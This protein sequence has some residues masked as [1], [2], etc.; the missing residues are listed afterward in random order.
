MNRDE[1]D[2]EESEESDSGDTIEEDNIEAEVDD[3]TQV[4]H[5][6]PILRGNL[7]T[8]GGM[9]GSPVLQQ[10]FLYSDKM[11]TLSR[12]ISEENNPR[13]RSSVDGT[14]SPN[15]IS[16][17]NS[18]QSVKS[19][20]SRLSNLS[21]KIS[22]VDIP[23]NVELT[24]G[25]SQSETCITSRIGNKESK[26]KSIQIEVENNELS[27][28]PQSKVKI[29]DRLMQK[30][31]SS[32]EDISLS[33]TDKEQTDVK[34][35]AD[36]IREKYKNLIK[37][38]NREFESGGATTSFSR[39]SVASKSQCGSRSHVEETKNAATVVTVKQCDTD[40]KLSNEV[41]GFKSSVR[42]KI[43]IDCNETTI[44][45]TKNLE[46]PIER[47]ENERDTDLIVIK[48]ILLKSADGEKSWSGDAE[49]TETQKKSP[50]KETTS[51]IADEPT[52][53]SISPKNL[54][55]PVKKME[56]RS[57][58]GSESEEDRQ[59]NLNNDHLN[60]DSVK[61]IAEATV[62]KKNLVADLEKTFISSSNSCTSSLKNESK[63][64]F[65]THK[66]ISSIK[67]DEC[68]E[69]SDI[70]TT[71][72]KMDLFEITSPSTDQNIV[73]NALTDP[74]KHPS[75][76]LLVEAHCQLDSEKI[77][78]PK[79]TSV[80]QYTVK[81]VE[82]RTKPDL[83][84]NTTDVKNFSSTSNSMKSIAVK[85]QTE[86]ETPNIDLDVSA[87]K[88]PTK[89]EELS[90]TRS[91]ES[92]S[93]VRCYNAANI[94]KRKRSEGKESGTSPKEY[95]KESGTSP[96]EYKKAVEVNKEED[97]S[98]PSNVQG[99]QIIE[100][101]DSNSSD[102]N[103]VILDDTQIDETNIRNIIHS[104]LNNVEITKRKDSVD[105]KGGKTSLIKNAP[106]ENE[107]NA[108]K[109]GSILTKQ[110]KTNSD[111]KESER[112]ETNFKIVPIQSILDKDIGPKSPDRS[113]TTSNSILLKKLSE[114]EASRTR[115]NAS[116]EVECVEIKSEPESSD[117]E[118][119]ETEYMEKKRTYMSALNISERI[120]DTSAPKKNE[121]RTRSKTEEIGKGKSLD[122]LSKIIDEVATTYS[123]KHEKAKKANDRRGSNAH[124]SNSQNEERMGSLSQENGEIF[125]KSFAKLTQQQLQLQQQQQQQQ[126]SRTTPQHR[127]QP[128]PKPN[129]FPIKSGQQAV[130]REMPQKPPNTEV[131]TSSLTR[132]TTPCSN[133]SSTNVPAPPTAG[134]TKSIEQQLGSS[135]NV[136]IL[137][138]PG[139]ILP[140]SQQLTYN[141]GSFVTFVPSQ[142]NM[143]VMQ[144]PQMI[145]AVM[146]S[147]LHQSENIQQA[148][149]PNV[150]VH[151]SQNYIPQ[152]EDETS[153]NSQTRSTLHPPN[154]TTAANGS[155]QT[156]NIRSEVPSLIP[157]NS[158]ESGGSSGSANNGSTDQRTETADD[159]FGLL[160]SMVP[161]SVSRAISEVLCRPPP[162]LKPRPPGPLSQVFDSGN[163]SSAGPVS[164]KINSISHRLGDYF[165]GMLIE[166]LEDLGKANNPEATIS[167]LKHEIE[168]L[169]HKHAVEMMDIR[170]N[171]CTILKDIQGS[172]AEE[173]ERII[174]ET[175]S[176]CE[177]EALRRIEEAKSKQWCANCGKEAQF[178]CCW[179]T[180]YCDYPC[181]QKHWSKHMG[182]CT[183]HAGQPQPSQSPAIRPQSQI[184]F[185][186]ATPKGFTGR[187]LAKP[188]KVY[189]N[190]S[191]NQKSVPTF[192]STAGHLTLV[193]TSNLEFL[194]ATSVP[195]TK[196]IA[197]TSLFTKVKTTNSTATSPSNGPVQQ[198]VVLN[199]KI[200]NL[201]PT[202][203]SPSTS[204]TV[205]NV[206]SDEEMESE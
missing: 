206:I 169:Q 201:Q 18:D 44:S 69:I 42:D 16:R 187:I 144:T 36:I 57:S 25:N 156:T 55:S 203:P 21:D 200:N 40:V 113:V 157:L 24:L 92:N 5:H 172:I 177:L 127:P 70:E 152:N 90:V 128:K 199:Q 77:N 163:P 61:I 130:R 191:N 166:M 178:Y 117:V 164:A 153:A 41:T 86:S 108:E 3:D 155:V 185:R 115:N 31:S 106:L 66:E 189:L 100:Q 194:T 111:E 132:I 59:Q 198:P 129:N 165:R 32:D 135:G 94:R 171:V 7:R 79:L 72:Q 99:S 13:K 174:D 159:E 181:Q 10:L 87:D 143:A 6:S 85:N 82:L 22:R 170:K 176:A 196:F 83:Q 26:K 116:D 139:V 56:V 53:K 35:Q 14:P 133:V 27:I 4:S 17:R 147:N 46:E 50:N 190:R 197:P 140:T 137:T 205:S 151:R 63:S 81:S 101:N 138:Q 76:N 146:T 1:E 80:K 71:E 173:R 162:R 39:S 142:Q 96:K 75:S 97:D 120:E 64:S 78:T 158:S 121:I 134:N 12:R 52:P 88:F 109:Q 107:T 124:T 15:K 184:T 131:P 91:S 28:S 160:H 188:T 204:N 192:K 175:R 104:S 67:S 45:S 123:A 112:R 182:K 30:L 49:A 186:P 2:E 65:S 84:K 136:L 150:E 110:Q 195:G 125:V 105:D 122:N 51:K 161:E 202:K 114:P 145:N 74:S 29:T 183:Q 102:D 9:N 168:T 89:S 98:K 93:E 23:E 60:D 126:Q 33:A 48:K 154:A 95:K 34:S 8:R 141:A 149:Q 54:H 43:E 118:M 20:S 68:I 193:D 19:D 38:K 11:K 148:R 62:L 180:S 37:E 58:N 73:K 47:K 103:E 119:E 179:N 167:T